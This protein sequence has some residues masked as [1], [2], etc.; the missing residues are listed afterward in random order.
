MVALGD[1]VEVSG[2]CIEDRMFMLKSSLEISSMA[3]GR[4]LEYQFFL[5]GA[6]RTE[7]QRHRGPKYQ[8][9]GGVIGSSVW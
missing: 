8:G 1:S 6:K 4:W 2:F 5:L 3:F 7:L 9:T